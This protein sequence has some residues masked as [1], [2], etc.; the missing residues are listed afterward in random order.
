GSQGGMALA[1]GMVFFAG[2]TQILLSGLLLR[3]RNVF[4]VEMAGLAVMLTGV[5]TG[6]VGLEVLFNVEE[7][8]VAGDDL[9]VAGFTLAVLVFCNIWVRTRFQAFTT[10]AGLLAGTVLAISL[11]MIP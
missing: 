3:M 9:A 8:M 10:L 7:Q 2:L 11:G 1:Y 6:K 4:T 5:A